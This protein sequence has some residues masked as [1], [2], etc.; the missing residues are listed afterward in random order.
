MQRVTRVYQREL[1]L[2]QNGGGPTWD[3][4]KFDFYSAR[5]ALQALY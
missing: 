5:N 1:I 3:S 4:L 2:V